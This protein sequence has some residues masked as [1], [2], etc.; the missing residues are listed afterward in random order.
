MPRDAM[1]R[2]GMLTIETLNVDLDEVYAGMHV[3]STP[4]PYVMMAVNDT[5]IGM[6]AEVRDQIFDPFFTTKEKG[7]GT[8]LGLSTVYGLSSRAT[9]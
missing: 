8:G 7:K 5:G 1:P 9:A 2:G 6:T 3:G 4:G